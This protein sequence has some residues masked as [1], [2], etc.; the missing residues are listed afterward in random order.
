MYVPGIYVV[1][2]QRYEHTKRDWRVL[3]SSVLLPCLFVFMAMGL[4]LLRPQQNNA[5]EMIL[6]P[7]IYGPGMSLFFATENYESRV[8]ENGLFTPTGVGIT[9][10]EDADEKL[11]LVLCRK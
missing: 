6:T 3:M 1:L 5:V 4:S 11:R 8:L 10:L 7:E 9:C 2:F